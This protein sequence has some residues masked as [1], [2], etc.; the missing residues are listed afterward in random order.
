[1]FRAVEKV[2]DRLLRATSALEQV[3]IPYAVI[4][5]CAVA[6]CIERID[7]SAVRNTNTVELLIEANDFDYAKHALLQAGLC[8]SYSANIHRFLD[9]QNTTLRNAIKIYFARVLV[10]VSGQHWK[11]PSLSETTR[12]LSNQYSHLA[13]EP[14]VAMQLGYNRINNKV[15]C[16]DMIDAGLI[17]QTWPAR[18]DPILGARL[19]ELLDD[20][21][22]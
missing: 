14:L 22:G 17:D 2:R 16:R 9:D 10:E 6:A 1:M 7:E 20:P 3:G 13:L 15:N 8:H 18:F 19:Q 12:S 5:D 4:G 11:L 21:E